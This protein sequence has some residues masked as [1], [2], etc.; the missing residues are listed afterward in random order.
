VVVCDIVLVA[1]SVV[2]FLLCVCV[3]DL[4]LFLH[5]GWAP[6]EPDPENKHYVAMV[7]PY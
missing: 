2:L 3:S 6:H 4:F 5:S 7:N 1:S